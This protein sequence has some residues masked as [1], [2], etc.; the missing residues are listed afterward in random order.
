MVPDPGEYSDGISA[1]V[2]Q[3]GQRE[4][5][6]GDLPSIDPLPL[7]AADNAADRQPVARQRREPHIELGHRNAAVSRDVH[8]EPLGR[9]VCDTGSREIRCGDEACPGSNE[10]GR[11]LRCSPHRAHFRSTARRH[12]TSHRNR[13]HGYQNANTCHDSLPCR[14]EPPQGD[15]STLRRALQRHGRVPHRRRARTAATRAEA[16]YH[17][18]HDGRRTRA[19]TEGATRG[20]RGPARLGPWLPLTP[21]D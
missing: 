21:I 8:R 14:N 1:G 19:L 7:A 2:L 5:T 17:R 6:V 4:A 16:E 20:D 10:L 3:L 13:S 11:Q 18:L 9:L 12:G 15:A